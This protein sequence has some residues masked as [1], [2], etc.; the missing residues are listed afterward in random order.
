M[1]KPVRLL[2]LLLGLAACVFS[3]WVAKQSG[4]YAYYVDACSFALI[5][6]GALGF[7]A[8]RELAAGHLA[9]RTWWGPAVLSAGLLVLVGMLAA[10]LFA[11]AA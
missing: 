8:L 5:G 1:A 2:L 9:V 11:L 10:R 4:T 6:I 3:V 7:P